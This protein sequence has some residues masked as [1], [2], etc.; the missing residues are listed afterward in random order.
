MRTKQL[1]SYK[2]RIMT[3]KNGQRHTTGV[4]ETRQKIKNFLRH[5]LVSRPVSD[6]STPWFNAEAGH[7]QD[8]SI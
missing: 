5:L 4:K 3:E 7:E 6:K 2:K 1:F 8:E